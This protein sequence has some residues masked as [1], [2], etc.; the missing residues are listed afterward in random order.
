MVSEI[1]PL[2][3]TE[4]KLMTHPTQGLGAMASPLVSTQFSALPR[5]SLV[6]LTHLGIVATAALLQCVIFRFKTQERTWY[7][8]LNLELRAYN[9]CIE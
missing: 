2:L 5:W 7:C 8:A 3:C 1:S 6:Y 9:N 4:S